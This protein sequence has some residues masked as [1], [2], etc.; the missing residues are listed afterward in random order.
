MSAVVRVRLQD[1]PLRPKRI[2]HPASAGAVLVFEGVV[3]PN[4]SGRELASLAYE[5][6]EPMTSR[7]MT[8]LANRV[9]GE[10]AA[11]AIH[12]EHSVGCVAVGE[13]SFR[14]SIASRHRAEGIA[15]VDKF[16][17]EM[18][19]IVPLWKNPIFAE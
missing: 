17:R 12:V 19:R 3:R 8:R 13:V 16:I 7:E 5:A 15:A 6:Y 18:K 10:H 9:A 2:E 11:L 1:G 4:E 14:L